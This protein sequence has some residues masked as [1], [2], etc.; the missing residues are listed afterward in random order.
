MEHIYYSLGWGIVA[1]CSIPLNLLCF[2]VLNRAKN[3][4]DV[5]KVFLYSL[6]ASDFIYCLFRVVPAISITATGRVLLGDHFCTIQSFFSHTAVYALYPTLLAVN[7]ER[8]I[9]LTYPLKYCLIVSKRRAI[10]GMAFI[11]CFAISISVLSGFHVNWKANLILYASMCWLFNIEGRSYI[12]QRV[13]VIFELAIIGVIVILFIKMYITAK[14]FTRQSSTLQSRV[15]RHNVK[16]NSKAATTF[17]L[18]TFTFLLANVP[19]IVLI[20]IEKMFQVK[21]PFSVYFLS[22]IMYGLAGIGDIIV[23]YFRNRSFQK[24]TKEILTG[25]TRCSCRT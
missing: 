5:T 22:E 14:R 8:Y 6:T 10:F 9:C 15:A 4:E 20:S 19:W 18:M 12:I 3:I 25:Y 2:V 13:M 1:V 7:V 21:V 23:Y 11:W 17:F 16:K 24:T